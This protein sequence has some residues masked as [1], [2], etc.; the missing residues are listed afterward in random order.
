MN[1]GGT[2]PAT[3][4]DIVA[5]IVAFIT[6][7]TEL[8]SWIPRVPEKK[9]KDEATRKI[10]V[11]TPFSYCATTGSPQSLAARVSVLVNSWWHHIMFFQGILCA[12]LIIF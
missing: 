5:T 3:V 2:R 4:Y 9:K 11:L 10:I 12:A 7:C 6:G 1:P 8:I